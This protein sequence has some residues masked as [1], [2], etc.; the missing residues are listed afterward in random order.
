[1]LLCFYNFLVN[2]ILVKDI[3]PDSSESS[4]VD[5]VGGFH[6]IVELKQLNI[7]EPGKQLKFS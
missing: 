1:M 2:K 7:S 3:I 6:F 4:L 5:K